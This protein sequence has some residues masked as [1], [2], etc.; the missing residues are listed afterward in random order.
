MV[1]QEREN[2]LVI[3]THGRS[4]YVIDLDPIHELA[5]PDKVVME[6]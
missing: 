1:I 6:N 3:G 4:V 5:S 2:D